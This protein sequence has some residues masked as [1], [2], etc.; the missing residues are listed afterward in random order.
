VGAAIPF[1]YPNARV[2]GSGNQGQ[3][4][5]GQGNGFIALEA[6][7]ERPVA[8]ISNKK[9][10]K[11]N[12]YRCAKPGHFFFDCSAILCD[13]C[14]PA[15]HK[16]DDCPLLDAL[17]PQIIVH[18]YADEK[19][20]FFECLIT[21]PYKPK[22]ESTRVGILLVT[23]GELSTPK[24]VAQLRRLVPSDDFHREIKQVGHN[25]FKV[26]DKGIDNRARQLSTPEDR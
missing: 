2:Q 13:Y 23:G 10:K 6:A 4:S 25:V 21:K 15:D 17:K 26:T 9:A 11:E 24:I 8:A 14:E 16:S 12:C 20:L 19:L 22:L 1:Q 3:R 7:N 5:D 18:G